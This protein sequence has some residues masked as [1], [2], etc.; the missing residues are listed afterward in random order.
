METNSIIVRVNDHRTSYRIKTNDGLRLELNK[1]DIGRFIPQ[2]G[3]SVRIQLFKGIILQEVWID[4]KLLIRNS[5]QKL[6]AE[7]P[8]VVS[9]LEDVAKQQEQMDILLRSNE[10]LSLP[11][12]FRNRLRLLKTVLKNEFTAQMLHHQINICRIAA[13]LSD[14]NNEYIACFESRQSRGFLQTEALDDKALF[15]SKQLVITLRNDIRNKFQSVADYERSE[16]LRYKGQSISY[17]YSPQKAVHRYL[18]DI[19]LG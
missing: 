12:A 19:G 11:L 10:F 18:E 1:A 4:N 17:P 3:M 5:P 13:F 8:K 16:T 2:N 9:Q 6:L 7:I 14:K 15:D